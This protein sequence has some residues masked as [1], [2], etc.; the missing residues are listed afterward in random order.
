MRKKSS[1]RHESIQDRNSIKDILHALT[2]GLEKGTLKFSDEDD[3]IILQP[4]GLLQVKLTASID[5]N[6]SKVNLRLSWQN[7]P[8]LK[9]NKKL[10]VSTGSKKKSK[11]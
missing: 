10:Q 7:N 5:D 1:F 8:G 4:K 2:T 11:K 6:Q 9:K 3:E